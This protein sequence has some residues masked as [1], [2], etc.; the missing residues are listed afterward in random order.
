MLNNNELAKEVGELAKAMGLV[1]TK[2]TEL[3]N[4]S[5]REREL[6]YKEL[7]A[8]ALTNT[9]LTQM[10]STLLQQT[11]ELTKVISSQKTSS[12]SQE[13]PNPKLEKALL[14]YS[15]TLTN[16]DVEM[17]KLAQVPKDLKELTKKQTETN[18]SLSS[19]SKDLQ[20]IDKPKKLWSSIATY[21]L[22]AIVV[23]T[24]FVLLVQTKSGTDFMVGKVNDMKI[25]QIPPQKPKKK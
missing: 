1:Y 12:N 13:A 25:I 5:K 18:T 23:I 15:Q 6:N 14:S 20:G 8:W 16:L 24:S 22:S 21:S 19:L 7:R 17:Q 9:S 4:E 11:Q 2:M 10:I 3:E